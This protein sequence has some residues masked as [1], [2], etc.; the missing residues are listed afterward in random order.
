MS[1]ADP[2]FSQ[3]GMTLIEIMVVVFIIGLSA[4]VVVM[5]LPPPKSGAAQAAE[6]F[7]S[8]LTLAQE[9]A[10]MTGF[11]VGLHFTE[12]GYTVLSWTQGRWRPDRR[13]TVLDRGLEIDIRSELAWPTGQQPP[14]DWPHIVFDPTG[15]N[16]A[17]DF[18]IRGRAERIDIVVTE[19]GEVQL[20]TP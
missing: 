1:R 8:T 12:T 14:E 7:S 18:R 13:P 5:T 15:V 20:D 6:R 2:F 4:G 16:S 17:L 3:R 10:I 19:T 11:P 9:R